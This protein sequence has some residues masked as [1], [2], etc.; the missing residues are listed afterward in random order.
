MLKKLLFVTVLL[1]LVCVQT[2]TVRCDL[3]CSLMGASTKCHS[4][5]A[6]MQMPHC[7]GMSKEQNNQTGLTASDS[8]AHNACRTELKAITKSADQKV[9]GSSRLLVSA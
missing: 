7:R 5:Q 8:C 9:A 6:D 2:L 3:L 1:L 4:L